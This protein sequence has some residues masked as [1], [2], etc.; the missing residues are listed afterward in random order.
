M[1]NPPLTNDSQP[2][3][4]FTWSLTPA[5]SFPQQNRASET[6]AASAAL[7]SPPPAPPPAFFSAP[8]EPAPPEPT[9][10]R[11]RRRC[12]AVDRNGQEILFNACCQLSDQ[13]RARGQR[14][15]F[16]DNVAAKYREETGRSY[17]G[18]SAKRTVSRE[19]KKRREGVTTGSEPEGGNWALALEAWIEIVVSEEQQEQAITDASEKR[20]RENERAKAIHNELLLPISLRSK[21]TRKRSR[22]EDSESET[23]EEEAE[24]VEEEDLPA[25]SIPNSS[26]PTPFPTS[27]AVRQSSVSTSLTTTESGQAT[28][29]QRTIPGA[30]QATR[31]R[32]KKGDDADTEFT[33]FS[34]V[35][36]KY[37]TLQ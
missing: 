33:G 17:I 5:P 18:S 19:V 1:E 11:R 23:E 36:T 29:A 25:S 3:R 7:R 6:S 10:P 8:P 35:A 2:Y 9:P 4:E 24:E 14:T 13:Y 30:R 26:S 37:L 27:G 22:A 31:H 20:Q 16:W 28:P 12:Q 34:R 15:K 21:E 32:R